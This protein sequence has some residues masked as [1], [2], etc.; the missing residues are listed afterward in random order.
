MFNLR[1]TVNLRRTA[2]L[3]DLKLRSTRQFEQRLR[4]NVQPAL[5]ADIAALTEEPGPAV[6]PFQFATDKSRAFYFWQFKGEI[7]YLRTGMLRDSWTFDIS[8]SGTPG[9]FAGLFGAVTG[10]I[11]VVLVNTDPA[12]IYVYGPRQVPGHRN[13]GWTAPTREKVLADIRQRVVA[14]WGPSVHA[15]LVEGF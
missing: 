3:K 4:T 10:N 5:E 6:Y 15:A 12:S 9:R 7:P 1:V 14:E 13:T 11:R 8:S 2:S